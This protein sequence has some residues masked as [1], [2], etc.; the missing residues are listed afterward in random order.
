MKVINMTPHAIKVINEKKEK[1]YEPCGEIVRLIMESKV[2][3]EVDGFEIKENVIVGHNLPEP[4]EGVYLIVSAMV[5]SALKNQ[6]NDLIA[7][8]TNEAIRDE[9]GRIIAVKSF[10]R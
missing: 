6:R 2:V 5:L 3:D 1:I 8:N 4:K 10:T 7:P 9:Q